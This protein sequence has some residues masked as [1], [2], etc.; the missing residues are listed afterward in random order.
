[1]P[2]DYMAQSRANDAY[3]A[4]IQKQAMTREREQPAVDALKRLGEIED[5]YRQYPGA[6]PNGTGTTGLMSTDAAGWGRLQDMQREY[7]N[8]TADL[9]GKQRPAVRSGR[10]V[11]EDEVGNASYGD[12]PKPFQP[13]PPPT[14]AS[15]SMFQAQM[16]P[17]SQVPEAVAGLRSFSR[18]RNVR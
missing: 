15:S 4:A 11:V 1:M 10:L 9:Q 13:L 8:L 17:G 18:R 3:L 12:I 5:Y 7:L 14:P 16:Q 2:I 6:A